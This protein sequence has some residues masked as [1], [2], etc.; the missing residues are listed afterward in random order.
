MEIDKDI[1]NEIGI[2]K[3]YSQK[4]PDK[5]YIGSSIFLRK[6]LIHHR[7]TLCSNK[8]RNKIL[9]NHVNK[10]GINDL[11]IEIIEKCNKENIINREQYYIDLLKPHFNIRMIADRNIGVKL[12]KEHIEAIKKS[13]KGKKFTKEHCL[14][15]SE[16]KKGKSTKSKPC[17]EETKKKISKANKGRI[18]SEETKLKLSEAG[19]KRKHSPESIEKRRLKIIGTKMTEEQKL[20]LSIA[21]R[22]AIYQYDLNYN[23]IKKWDSML[24]ASKELN[25]N[26]NCISQCCKGKIKRTGKYIFK[27][28][29]IE[30]AKPLL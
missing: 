24:S 25:L 19:K 9:Q 8:H 27:K 7:C 20:K 10:Y 5:I 11:K 14:R 3:I 15:I 6:R 12:S 22:I 13:M 28:E 18:I 16:S 29:L 21:R 26:I 1:I 4:Y 23:F 2:Y 17:S 30:T